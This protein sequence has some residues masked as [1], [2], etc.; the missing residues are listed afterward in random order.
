[1]NKTQNKLKTLLSVFAPV[2]Y[3]DRK[4]TSEEWEDITKEIIE[5]VKEDKDNDSK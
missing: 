2:F 1:M 5:I 3:S 4:A